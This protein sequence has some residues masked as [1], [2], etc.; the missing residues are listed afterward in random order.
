MQIVVVIGIENLNILLISSQLNLGFSSCNKQVP[1]CMLA[2]KFSGKQEIMRAQRR[3]MQVL[4]GIC[5]I[6]VFCC[7]DSPAVFGI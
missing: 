3:W 5:Q 6:P 2:M 1:L 7:L 4:I